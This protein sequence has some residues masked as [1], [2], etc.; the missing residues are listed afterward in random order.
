MCS[1][2]SAA[3]CSGQGGS[4]VEEFADLRQIQRLQFQMRYHEVPHDIQL[5]QVVRTAAADNRPVASGLGGQPVA[6]GK[7]LISARRVDFVRQ[8]VQTV[9]QPEDGAI[10]CKLVEGRHIRVGV[11]PVLIQPGTRRHA[12]LMPTQLDVDRQS[13][14]LLLRT[15]I[16]GQALQQGGLAAARRTLEQEDRVYLL[17]QHLVEVGIG[18]GLRSRCIS[19]FVVSLFIQ[20]QQQRGEI[21][22]EVLSLPVP[23]PALQAVF[24]QAV[25]R[26][27][28]HSCFELCWMYIQCVPECH[29]QIEVRLSPGGVGFW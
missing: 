29:R 8:L 23:E 6:P 13:V 25:W 15:E 24:R 28:T 10:P 21:Q 14:V 19:G 5:T 2:A 9:Q 3:C 12:T 16:E 18:F 20:Q 1:T 26:R 17:I 4:V 11:T 7:Y 22:P 27:V